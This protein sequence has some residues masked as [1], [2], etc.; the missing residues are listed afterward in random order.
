MGTEGSELEILMET[1]WSPTSSVLSL[2]GL[3]VET[4]Y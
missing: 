1:S 4:A 2:V 3:Q